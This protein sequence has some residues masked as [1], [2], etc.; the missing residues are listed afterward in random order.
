MW[1][2]DLEAL[3][4]FWIVHRKAK[5]VFLFEDSEQVFLW[6]PRTTYCHL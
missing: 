3:S 4:I 6:T 1:A 5:L 2:S